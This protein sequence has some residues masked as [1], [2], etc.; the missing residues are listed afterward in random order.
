[1]LRKR[2]DLSIEAARARAKSKSESNSSDGEGAWR[3][4]QERRRPAVVLPAAM[5]TASRPGARWIQNTEKRR[6]KRAQ[7]RLG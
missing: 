6:E 3:Q 5:L 4:H 7:E 2:K 1:M